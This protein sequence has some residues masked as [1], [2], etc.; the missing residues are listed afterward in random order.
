EE[1][2]G[3]VADD[4]LLASVDRDVVAAF[5]DDVHHGLRLVDLAAELI[6]VRDLEI[7]AELH[8]ARVGLELADQDA[9]QRRLSDAVVADYADTVAAH[10]AEREVVEELLAAERVRDVASLDHLAARKLVRLADQ[11]P[12]AAR[13]LDAFRSLG[14]HRLERTDSSLV[15]V[16]ARL[17]ALANPRLF[18]GK[19]LVEEGVLPI[20][21]GLRARL[22]LEVLAVTARPAP[23][24]APIEI[25][26]ARRD[27]LHERA[28]VSDEEHRA[29][30]ARDLILEP[31][32]RA[33]IEV[34]GRFVQQQQV[35]SRDERASE[36]RPTPPSP[37][38][39][40]E[41]RIGWKRELGDDRVD[42]SVDG[43]APAGNDLALERLH[44]AQRCASRRVARK[45]LVCGD[46]LDLFR[47]ALAN[48]IAHETLGGVGKL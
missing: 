20:L 1:K 37:G 5:A 29:R 7:R 39:L 31:L 38:E 30:E 9:Q 46:A 24:L 27:A 6:E 12:R 44:L 22:L 2:V 10:D 11:D 33:D 45:P 40:V 42:L 36:G 17:D 8:A 16:L 21:L 19:L 23:Q 14:A 15:A 25:D 34:I 47:H 26:D 28:I 18:L 35:R 43:P 32:D 13:T 3:K 48:E 4:V 41:P